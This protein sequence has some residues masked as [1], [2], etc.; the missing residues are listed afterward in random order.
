MNKKKHLVEQAYKQ[1]ARPETGKYPLLYSA[2]C[3]SPRRS[4]LVARGTHTPYRRSPPI[5]RQ[6]MAGAMGVPRRVSRKQE[7][8]LSSTPHTV[9][10]PAVPQL[11][12]EGAR[13]RIAGARPP[14]DKQGVEQW[15]EQEECHANRNVSSPPRRILSV[16]PPSLHSRKRDPY[17]IAQETAY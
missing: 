12:Q 9:S 1:S 6:A 15:L 13:P 16:A 7:H 3:Q 10:R 5:E 17:P 8:I 14:S 4:S 2:S 11:A